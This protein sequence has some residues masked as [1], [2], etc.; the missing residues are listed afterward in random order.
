M[1]GLS[2]VIMFVSSLFLMLALSASLLFAQ[3][4]GAAFD[5]YPLRSANTSSPRDTLRSFNANI[6][7][8][9]QARRAGEPRAVVTR[10]AQRAHE[11]FDF[12]QLPGRGR[13]AKEVETMLFLKEILDRIELPPDSEI[14][15]EGQSH[16]PVQLQ[17]VQ[18]W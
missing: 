6:I 11:T 5:P 2:R 18:A 9:V 13:F 14:P 12:S 10:A 7:K 4:K 17:A 16:G 1:A 3:D 15:G 8:A